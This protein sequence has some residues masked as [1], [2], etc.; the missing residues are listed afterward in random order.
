MAQLGVPIVT[1]TNT[2]DGL[3]LAWD[4]IA[5]GVVG[6]RV[7]VQSES[8]VVLVQDYDASTQ[9]VV[10][11][12][13]P[14]AYK[15]SVQALGD[16]VLTTDSDVV[17]YDFVYEYPT[18]ETVTRHLINLTPKTYY[19]SEVFANGDGVVYEDSE[20]AWV[21]FATIDGDQPYFRKKKMGL[22]QNPGVFDYTNATNQVI[23]SGDPVVVGELA[24]V[25]VR[26]IGVG[27]T[28]AV[29][30]GGIYE[31]EKDNG[32]IALGAPVYVGATSGKVTAT[33][34]GAKIGYCV[35]AAA[36]SE[37]FAQV[38]LR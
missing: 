16:G 26:A 18:N 33:N 35:K 28:G 3:R 29:S 2:D 22:L 10:V 20:S 14:G 13:E 36:A 23:K 25:A 31:F 4:Y 8:E 30:V 27:E 11:P 37:S 34:Q 5:P 12:A 38:M 24:G 17:N 6:F 19:S 1:A 32:E 15:A 7:I 9:S 21:Y